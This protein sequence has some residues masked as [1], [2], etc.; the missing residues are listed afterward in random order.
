MVRG[1][2]GS[3]ASTSTSRLSGKMESQLRAES[4]PTT[5]MVIVISACSNVPRADSSSLP[6]A[7]IKGV[8]N[9]KLIAA[10]SDA[11]C[12]S[13]RVGSPS[14]ESSSRSTTRRRKTRYKTRNWRLCRMGF[15]GM[16]QIRDLP[17]HGYR[18]LLDG[19]LRED[20]FERRQRHEGLEPFDRVVGHDASAMQDDDVRA[21]A[22]HGF[23]FMRAEENHFAPRGQ[24]LDEAAQD[25][26]RTDIEAREW[27]IQQDEVGIMQQCRG[28]QHL[29]PHPLGVGRDGEIAVSVQRQQVQ[30]PI[31]ALR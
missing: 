8:Q 17:G 25:Q 11:N 19:Q 1:F 14:A 5:S 7:R 29:L 23:Q 12:P 21:D 4:R 27:L 31:D 20:F 24:F 16:D 15:S 30:Q 9:R 22:L 6:L 10:N 2:T 28:Q 26:R 13:N 18:V 3:G